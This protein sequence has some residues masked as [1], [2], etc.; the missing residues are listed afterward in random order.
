[1]VQIVKLVT[2]EA[3]YEV[4]LDDLRETLAQCWW[5]MLC[6]ILIEEDLLDPGVARVRD[7][8]EGVVV[9][10][11][12]VAGGHHHRPHLSI[13]LDPELDVA[14]P[15]HDVHVSVVNNDALPLT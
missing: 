2:F 3:W 10:G 13:V 12:L 7:L 9:P 14:L 5:L 8:P 6:S 4:D 1:M 15:R 11:L